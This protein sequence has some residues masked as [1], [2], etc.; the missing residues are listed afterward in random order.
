MSAP[1]RVPNEPLLWTNAGDASSA[2]ARMWPRMLVALFATTLFTSASLMFVVEPMV[3][4][5]VLP[6]L[7]GAPAV[8]NTCLVFFQAMLLAGYAY[9]HGA[10]RFFGV[11]RHVLVHGVVILLPLLVLPVGLHHAAPDASQGPIAWLLLVLCGSIGLPFFVLSTSAAVLQTWFAATD[12]ESAGDPYFLYT[13]S[14]LG[15]FIALLA[16]PIVI[17]PT[18]RLQDQARLWSFG[19]GAF[20]ALT[21][22][23]A[24]VVWCRS[25]PAGNAS[26]GAARPAAAGESIAW[27]RRARWV[28]L[29]FVPSSLLLAVTTYIS[30][31]VASVPLLWIA[32]L[33]LYLL[34]FVIAFSPKAFRTRALASR[35]MPLFVLVLT[36]IL[37]SDITSPLSV[38]IPLHLA[39]FFVIAVACH[40]NLADDRPSASRLTE[41]YFWISCG[42]M[43]GGLFNALLAPVV[44]N[45]I[46]EYPLVIVAACLLHGVPSGDGTRRI[47]L[48]DLFVPS[49]VGLAIAG[50]VLVNNH[51]HSSRYIVL[52]AALPALLVYTQRVHRIRFAASI[53][54]ILIA[55]TLAQSLFGRVVY[56]ERT[57]FGVNRVR[58]D[59][60]LGYR[61]MF[62]GPTLHGMQSLDP[63]RQLEPTSYYHRLGPIG[64]VLAAVPQASAASDVALIGLGIG[65]LASYRAPA[66][67]WTYYEIDPVVEQIA[68]NGGYFTYLSA[69]GVHC[70]IIT[71]DGR[72]SLARAEPHTYGVIVLDAFSSDAVP[73]HL[74]TKESLALYVS[75]LA[76]G[77]VIAFNISNIQ[78]SFSSVLARMADDA[79]L[80]ALWQQE[81]PDAGSWAIGKFPSEWFIVARSRADFGSL[82]SDPRWKV[83]VPRAD[84]PLW[85]DDFSNILSALR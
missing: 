13:A 75:K 60:R 16:Y 5:M 22:A 9:A 55:G 85:T 42:G 14:N 32:P 12:D 19:Y 28:A 23:C 37:I 47:V 4:R 61:F 46:I 57:F 43:L 33:A 77:G 51:F 83:P 7:G 78:L 62:H 36:L 84:T 27:V 71:G 31:D 25:A 40:A 30:T 50:T 69:C 73:M 79:G 45:S 72:I 52:E 41:F 26:A 68:S 53:A 1:A 20:V 64:Q 17:E 10:T 74:M 58:V 2:R 67:R 63:I 8:W 54:A 70:R 11:R 56:T 21:L 3:A 65:T 34:S 49:V 29:A 15:S 35:L 59:E 6:M 24:A 38:I 48:A 80:V 18:L 76:P 39:V 44:F 82:T 81:P 66:Q